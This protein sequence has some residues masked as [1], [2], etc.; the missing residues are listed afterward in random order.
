MKLYAS[1]VCHFIAQL[2][3]ADP[4]NR[5]WQLL[6]QKFRLIFMIKILLNQFFEGTW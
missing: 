5:A 4:E 2:K 3:F 1:Y 6:S